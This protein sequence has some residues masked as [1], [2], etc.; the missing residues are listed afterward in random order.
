MYAYHVNTLSVQASM[1]AADIR[2]SD[3]TNLLS[4]AWRSSEAI[5]DQWRTSDIE[6]IIMEKAQKNICRTVELQGNF[7]P[8]V[9]CV[10]IRENDQQETRG[11]IILTE[12]QTL[13]W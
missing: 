2:E 5:L 6:A 1:G 11:I 12:K 3:F 9:W 7:L 4:F 8:V 10:N 13:T